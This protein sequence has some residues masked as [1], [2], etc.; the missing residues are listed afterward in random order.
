MADTHKSIVGERAKI[1]LRRQLTSFQN[2]ERLSFGRMSS[3]TGLLV[4]VST[5]PVG[6]DQGDAPD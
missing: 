6:L 1:R 2:R 4:S 5:R 3:N